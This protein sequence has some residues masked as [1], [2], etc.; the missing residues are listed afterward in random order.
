MTFAIE[1]V[2]AVITIISIWM[3]TDEDVAYYPTGIVSVLLYAWIFFHARLYAET[4][5]QGV[6]LVL[7][8]YGW[9]AW[10]HGGANRAPLPV[11]RTPRWGWV[12]A[13]ICGA[14][15][16]AIIVFIQR[17]YTD[18]PAPFVD[19]AIAAWSVVAQWMT[20]RK[21]LENWLFWIAVNLA[22]VPLYITRALW[23]T[24]AL[25]TIL[26]IL[27]VKGYRDWKRSL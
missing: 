15:M 23:A 22:A 26:L 2:A 21:W 8:I 1:I 11:S 6:W 10:L 27:A 4:G 19:S 17:R 24:A 18:N 7:M 9:H 25:Y 20:A 14:A 16:T 12:T 13:V 5:L 3:A